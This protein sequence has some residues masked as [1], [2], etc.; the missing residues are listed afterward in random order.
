MRIV[1]DGGRKLYN[2]KC[3]NSRSEPKY[4][5][6]YLIHSWNTDR[7]GQPEPV[8]QELRRYFAEP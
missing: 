7:G 4:L 8:A 1:A 2:C 5:R 3:G 6:E